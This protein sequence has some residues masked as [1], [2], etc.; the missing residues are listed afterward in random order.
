MIMYV[1]TDALLAH[2]LKFILGFA[3]LLGKCNE[4]EKWNIMLY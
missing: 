4:Q 1:T 3:L 2:F